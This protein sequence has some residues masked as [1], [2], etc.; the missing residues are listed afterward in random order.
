MTHVRSH[1]PGI[2]VHS[3]VGTPKE[4]TSR[5]ATSR[6]GSSIVIYATGLGIAHGDFAFGVVR[7]IGGVRSGRPAIAA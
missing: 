4:N 6:N 5:A 3:H 7:G 1:N 2:L